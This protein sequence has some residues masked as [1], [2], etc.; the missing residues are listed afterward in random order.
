MRFSVLDPERFLIWFLPFVRPFFSW[1]GALLWLVVVG[2]GISQTGFWL[3]PT[4]FSS[5]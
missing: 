2:A 4:F 5:G 3:R 1:L